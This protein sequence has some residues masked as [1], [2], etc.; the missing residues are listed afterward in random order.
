VCTFTP[1]TAQPLFCCKLVCKQPTTLF[2]LPPCPTGPAC[3][4]HAAFADCFHGQHRGWAA[5]WC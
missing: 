1:L 2:L 5:H 3:L 4:L